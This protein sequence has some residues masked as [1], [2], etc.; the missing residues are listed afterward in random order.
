M[1]HA[2]E[3]A[4]IYQEVVEYL[5]KDM[6]PADKFEV[7]SSVRNDMIHIALDVHPSFRGR[8]IGRGGRIARSLR[9]VLDA[10]A[11]GSHLEPN[12]DIVD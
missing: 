2:D 3:A 8:V 6:V 11:S 7:R 4:T 12:L 9:S 5:V 1:S 10:V